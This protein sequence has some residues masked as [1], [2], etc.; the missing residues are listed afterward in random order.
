VLKLK[1]GGYSPIIVLGNPATRQTTGFQI[2]KLLAFEPAGQRDLSDPRVEQEIRKEL[3]DRREQLLKTA[4]YEVMRDRAKVQN[5]YA[6][7]LL[8]ANGAAYGNP[9]RIP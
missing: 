6:Q 7:Q 2:V 4:Y 8:E 5:Y 3:Q 9:G 1:P